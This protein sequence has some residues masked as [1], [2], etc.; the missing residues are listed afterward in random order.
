MQNE[1]IIVAAKAFL[2]LL[3]ISGC[4]TT[5][6]LNNKY[7]SI[8]ICTDKIEVSN[9]RFSIK[10]QTEL[11]RAKERLTAISNIPN[12][13]AFTRELRALCDGLEGKD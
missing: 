10:E 8:K 12:K 5:G 3:E 9:Q 13:E 1:R 4:D 7:V 11:E 6:E 2:K